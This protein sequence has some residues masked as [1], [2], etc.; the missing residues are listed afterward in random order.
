M[1]LTF[2]KNL[3]LLLFSK[4]QEKYRACVRHLISFAFFFQIKIVVPFQ[5]SCNVKYN[6]QQN[7]F[8][9]GSASFAIVG[10]F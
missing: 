8:Y 7:S 5:V 6:N 4:R 1:P 9:K 2:S 3:A 10:K